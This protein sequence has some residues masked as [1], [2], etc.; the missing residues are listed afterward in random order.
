[1]VN[2]VSLEGLVFLVLKESLV[3][4]VYQDCKGNEV[5]KEILEADVLTVDLV[6]RVTKEKEVSMVYKVPLVQ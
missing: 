5:R 1:M 6:R 2:P 3:D 4:Q